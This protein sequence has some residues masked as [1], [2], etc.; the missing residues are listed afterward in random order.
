MYLKKVEGVDVEQEERATDPLVQKN[1][2]RVKKT[3]AAAV[4]TLNLM[5]SFHYVPPPVSTQSTQTQNRKD[6]ITLD[7][8]ASNNVSREEQAP[9]E[10]ISSVNWLPQ[11]ENEL[12]QHDRKRKRR[13]IKEHSKKK[14]KSAEE[15]VDQ[16]QPGSKKQ[17]DQL[18]KELSESKGIDTDQRGFSSSKK[19]FNIIAENLQKHGTKR[20]NKK[21]P[22]VEESSATKK[23]YKMRLS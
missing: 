10:I 11:G 2:D 9:Q 4:H 15:L 3:V 6:A 16:I 14:F 20:D 5:S 1:K 7:V 13:T 17:R 12:E 8:D 22:A 21:L 18:A 23:A 19:F